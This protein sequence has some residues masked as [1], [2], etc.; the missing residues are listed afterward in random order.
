MTSAEKF[1]ESWLF[2]PTVGKLVSTIVAILIVLA[3]VRISRRIL[4]RY[5]QEPGNLYRAR[6][7]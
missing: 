6:R 4:S 1:V 7:W 5:V 3:L 2:D